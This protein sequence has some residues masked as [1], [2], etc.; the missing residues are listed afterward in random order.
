[1][2]SPTQRGVELAG[3]GL[4][5]EVGALAQ[6][7]H[8][9]A[10]RDERAP[11]L[12]DELEDALQVGLAA[13]GARDRGRRLEGGHGALELVAAAAHV[14]VQARVLDRDRRPAGEDD[15]RLLV[16]LVELAALLLGEVEVAVGLAAD[17]DRHAEEA[18]HRR[19]V[20]RKAVGLRVLA[21]V[22]Q[23]QRPRLGDQHPEDAVA[24]RQLA[25]RRVRG[26]VDARP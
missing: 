26:V 9:R 4:D 19:V 14:A 24:A 7:D 23:P 11:A 6:L 2:R 8:H 13:D 15:E 12:G 21:D 16:G 22:A 25:D 1:M 17:E 20:E 3:G 18:V 5:H 10:R